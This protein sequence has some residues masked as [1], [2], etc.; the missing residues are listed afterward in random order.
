VTSTPTLVIPRSLT[1]SAVVDLER[2]RRSAAWHLQFMR[3]QFGVPDLGAVELL[4]V[5]CGVK[6]A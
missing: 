4:D 3:E 6:L 2:E 5:G 1:R